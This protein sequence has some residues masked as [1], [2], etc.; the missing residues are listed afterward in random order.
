MRGAK[1]T[2]K[3]GD[4]FTL[5][6]GST[7]TVVYYGG[8]K[9]IGIKTDTGYEKVVRSSDLRT[10]MVLD[11]LR[12]TVLGVG[13][14]GNGKRGRVTDEIAYR[15]W[16]EM[17]RDH[18]SG[19]FTMHKDWLNFQKFVAWFDKAGYKYGMRPNSLLIRPK[20]RI[21]GPLTTIFVPG[22]L[23]TILY[24]RKR[25]GEFKYPVGVTFAKGSWRSILKVHGEIVHCKISSTIEEAEIA[26]KN[27]RGEY[28]LE[29]LRN[30]E[31]PI[32]AILG[33][34]KAAKELITSDT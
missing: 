24:G 33:A 9:D 34:T 28:V 7:A 2:I 19:E 18:K 11:R 14:I 12:A 27:A 26:Y 31:I 5:T 30:S 32:G 21:H 10:G 16:M 17:I 15:L 4:T 29:A 22:W 13:H 1:P 3:V 25:K 8:F 20:A 23:N 6:N